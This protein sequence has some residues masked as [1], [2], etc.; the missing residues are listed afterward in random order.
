MVPVVFGFQQFVE[1]LV[2]VGLGR[3]DDALAGWAAVVFLSFGMAF[4][5][6]WIPFS[7]FCADPRTVLRVLFGTMTLLALAWTWLYLPILL[8]PKEFLVTEVAHH[9]MRYDFRGIP[10]YAVVPQV[11]WRVG[12]LMLVCVPFVA[13]WD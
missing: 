6:F 10:G 8:H 3:H 7:F 2:W 13:S 11:A 4:Y 1:G 5:P 12:Y 9:S